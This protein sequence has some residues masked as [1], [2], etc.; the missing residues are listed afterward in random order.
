MSDTVVDIC[1]NFERLL[2]FGTFVSNVT[3]SSGLL[4]LVPGLPVLLVKFFAARHFQKKWLAGVSWK[5][6]LA[7][8]LLESF[9]FAFFLSGPLP[10]I[11]NLRCLFSPET[12][13]FY[14]PLLSA[15]LIG[16]LYLTPPFIILAVNWLL[17][18]RAE[19]R[20]IEKL[21]WRAKALLGIAIAGTYCLCLALIFFGFISLLF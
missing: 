5:L 4:L 10:L 14:P 3:K 18:S 1:A 19:G 21:T 11:A 16:G 6:L 8:W 15:L 9:A 17:L 13:D 20:L 2:A 7:S 12:T